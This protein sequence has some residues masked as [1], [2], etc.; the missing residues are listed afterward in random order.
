[1]VKKKSWDVHT[2]WG[3]ENDEQNEKTGRYRSN[4]GPW[5]STPYVDT[6]I[7]DLLLLEPVV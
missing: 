2:D 6:A 1:M 5:R 3:V 7:W 4:V